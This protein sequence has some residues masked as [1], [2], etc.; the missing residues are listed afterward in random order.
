VVGDEGGG[1]NGNGGTNGDGGANGVVVGE[2]VSLDV[3][4]A[5]SEALGEAEGLADALRG[6]GTQLARSG[7]LFD[8]GAHSMHAAAPGEGAKVPGCGVRDDAGGAHFIGRG[9][10]GA[11]SEASASCPAGFMAA[12]GSAAKRSQGPHAGVRRAANNSA[13]GPCEA[14]AE[15]TR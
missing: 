13:P 7:A 4:V 2:A 14:L 3:G 8:P 9:T 11:G 12:P 6:A 5:E 1:A 10:W 15:H